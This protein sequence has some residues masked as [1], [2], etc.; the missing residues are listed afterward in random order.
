MNGFHFK[1]KNQKGNT[2]RNKVLVVNGYIVIEKTLVSTSKKCA[3]YK[4][5]CTKLGLNHFK[6]ETAFKIDTFFTI[7]ENLIELNLIK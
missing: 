6:H 5:T 4:K 1:T 7:A 2:V 3:G